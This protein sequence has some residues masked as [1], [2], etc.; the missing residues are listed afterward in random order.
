MDFKEIEYLVASAKSNNKLS[1][2]N[3]AQEFRPF[4]I[5]LSNRTFINGYDQQDIQNECYRIL[6]K[7]V[8]VY[9]LSKHRF[10]AYA[11]NGIKNSINDLIKKTKNRSSAEG[12]EALTL[13]DNLEHTLPSTD[14]SLEE[15]LCNKSEFEL[16]RQ[17]F[18]NLSEEEKELITFVYFKNNSLTNFAYWKNMCYSTAN[19]KKRIILSKM[20]TY[21]YLKV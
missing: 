12:S 6:F 11:T 5:N 21:L 15:M 4:I 16:L 14:L 17:A 8:S 18:D 20:K 7:C 9:D 19:R 10:V 3:L 13:S 2:E 1:K